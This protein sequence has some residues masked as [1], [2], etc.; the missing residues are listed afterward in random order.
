MSEHIIYDCEV[1]RKDWIV[2]FR[3]V[4][5]DRHVTFHN[6]PEGLMEYFA[7]HGAAIFFGCN[8]KNYD[9]HIIRAIAAG[10]TPGM[11]KDLSD[12]IVNG[13]QA[14]DYR[15]LRDAH[16]YF[17]TSDLFDDM[18]VGTSLK[19]IEAHRGLDIHETEVD[20]EI[21]RALTSDELLKEIAYCRAD[22][23]ATLKYYELRSDYLNTKRELGRRAGLS[24]AKSLYMT[25]AKL[26][27]AF[28]GA[29]RKEHDDERAYTF[30]KN[31]LYDY[32]PKKVIDFFDKIH[33]FS[34]PDKELFESKLN[35]EI[36]PCL[37]T[38]GY[39]GI[40]GAIPTYREKA[41]KGRTIRNRDVQSYYPNLVVVEGYCSRN[42]PD[43]DAYRLVLEERL[44]AKRKK[45]KKTANALKLVVNTF[46][47]AMLS[48]YNDLYDPLM[49]RSVCITGQ[50]RLLEL[51]LHL[52]AEC[53]SLTIIQLNT[54]GIMVSLD[55]KDVDTYNAICDEWQS[56]TKFVL[57]E[58]VINEIIQ[59]DVN[60]YIEVAVNGEY[61]LKGGM[62]VRGIGTAGAFKINNNATIIPEAVVNYLVKGTPIFST[63][64]GCKDPAQ[65]QLIAKAS[66]KYS[67]VYQKVGRGYE[68]V[69]R[70]NR[71][72]AGKD[73]MH[74]GLVKVSKKTGEPCKIPN[75]P[76][77]CFVD[78]GSVHNVDLKLVD[79]DWYV[80]EANSVVEAFLGTSKPTPDNR[81]INRLTRDCEKL[82]AS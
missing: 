62:L 42:I 28:L 29:K 43:P 75:L 82:L 26:T 20:F 32:I 64:Y 46:F 25:N 77:R 52:V 34:I 40:H 57:E 27:A 78:N 74:G 15:L 80:R 13:G 55:D 5:G 31:I 72:F 59:K 17:N 45:D 65:F 8:V 21:D 6:N 54:D 61:K 63:V 4:G 53:P 41:V 70:C 35:F 1:F 12:Y 9:N 16:F 69:Q 36:G 3:A 81:K 48:K 67:D 7:Q 66:G 71:V 44:I 33:D 49:G 79:K 11:L 47:G 68:T 56:R 30:P 2:D 18:T 24:E 39:G 60:N 37:V 51:A 23:D 58:D 76:A 19:S 73:W 10:F 38:L 22:V 50:L 14:W